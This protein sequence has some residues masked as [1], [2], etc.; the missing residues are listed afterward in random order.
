MKN[1]ILRRSSAIFVGA[2]YFATL[3]SY[4][5]TLNQNKLASK[6]DLLKKEN[7]DLF[8]ALHKAENNELKRELLN[9]KLTSLSG[10]LKDKVENTLNEIAKLDQIKPDAL[11]SETDK[12]HHVE[13]IVRDLEHYNSIA[14]EII[15]AVNKQN[16]FNNFLPSNNFFDS[17]SNFFT[18]WNNMLSNLSIL[19]LSSLV[20]LLGA[21]TILLFVINVMTIVYAD[22]LIVRFKLEDKYPKLAKY[23]KIRRLFQQFYLAIDFCIIITVLLSVIYVNYVALFS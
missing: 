18:N 13:N 16:G 15:D 9:N 12:A 10:Q 4:L 1:T 14:Q 3:H 17:I 2:T 5:L 21:I 22:Y 8:E 23:I 19:E 20:H 11:G 6:V 7:Q